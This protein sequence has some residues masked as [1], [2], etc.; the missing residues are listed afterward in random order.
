[1]ALRIPSR[2]SRTNGQITHES[3]IGQWIYLLSQLDEVTQIVEIGAW[4]GGGS[5]KLIAQGMSR[6]STPNQALCLEA[7]SKMFEEA[8]MR[9]RGSKGVKLLW[10]SLVPATD[11]DSTDLSP[12]EKNGYRKIL[13][14]SINAPLC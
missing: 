4:R 6:R 9:H 2:F 13:R 11:L 10:G 5:T 8:Q 12:E 1:M 3:L 14:C 7:D